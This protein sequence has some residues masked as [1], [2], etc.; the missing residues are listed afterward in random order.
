MP[1]HTGLLTALARDSEHRPAVPHTSQT[2]QFKFT[3][4]CF[5]MLMGLV[6]D[7]CGWMF[8]K[9]TATG[10]GTVAHRAHITPSWDAS[11]SSGQ[12]LCVCKIN[13]NERC[14]HVVM[15]LATLCKARPISAGF[16]V[17]EAALTST[18]AL[19]TSISRAA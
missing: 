18:M 13:L 16:P 2:R 3:K 4:S 5:L 9:R 6:V 11:P 12:G 10:P 17:A 7:M 15:K 19:W 1:A 8:A 14:R